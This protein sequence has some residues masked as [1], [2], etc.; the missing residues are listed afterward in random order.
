MAATLELA[1]SAIRSGR[2]EEG[3]QLLNLLIQQNPNN[4]KAWLWMSSVVDTDE[5]RARCLYHVLAIDPNSEIARKGLQLLGIVVS[6]SRPVKIPRDSQPIPIPKPSDPQERRPFLIDPQAIAN[7]L[8]FTPVSKPVQASPSVLAIDVEKVADKPPH[9]SEPVP[10]A[11]STQT[12]KMPEPGQPVS[13]FGLP[14]QPSK[15]TDTQPL[16]ENR[17][18]EP[19]PAQPVLPA[20]SPAQHPSEPTPLEGLQQPGQPQPTASL[21]P[22]PPQQPAGPGGQVPDSRPYQPYQGAQPVQFNPQQPFGNPPS[23]TR[24]SQ[25]VPVV[26]H[27]QWPYYPGQPQMFPQHADPT[28]GMPYQPQ[29]QNPSQP[30]S[31]IHSSS[32]LGMPPQFQ[33]GYGQNPSEPAPV[34]HS[35]NTLGMSPYGQSYMPFSPSFHSSATSM[36]PGMSEAEARAR[37]ASSQGIPAANPTAMPLQNAASPKASRRVYQ[38][39]DEDEEGDDE[40]VNILAVIIFGTLSVTALGGLGMLILLMFTTPA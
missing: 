35:Q 12:Q 24:P 23:E 20:F 30:V 27:N 26:G 4:D 11:N 32:T 38:D 34:I 22:W 5:Q 36:M 18:S 2:K 33:S 17:P 9:P 6:D 31:S 37:L 25:P 16:P 1:I 19:V 7:E 21:Q 28:L 29:A 39:V 3:R 40:G 15:E 14:A 8:P 13:G 10:V